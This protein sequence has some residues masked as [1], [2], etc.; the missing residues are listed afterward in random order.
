MASLNH[1]AMLDGRDFEFLFNVESEDHFSPDVNI[2]KLNKHTFNDTDLPLQTPLPE[3][4][5]VDLSHPSETIQSRRPHMYTRQAGQD[6]L[7]KKM[8]HLQNFDFLWTR[9]LSANTLHNSRLLLR[10]TGPPSSQTPVTS[11]TS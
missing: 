10:H 9:L 11:R 6:R 3:S 5:S 4:A 8:Q 2:D 1:T 7:M